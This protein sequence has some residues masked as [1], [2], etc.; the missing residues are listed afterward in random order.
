MPFDL[1][2]FERGLFRYV[3]PLGVIA[4]LFVVGVYAYLGVFSRYW[5][6]D[7]CETVR[8]QN[9]SSPITAILQRYEEG[10]WRAANRYSNLTFVG[11]SEWLGPNNL[12][13]TI[14][15]MVLLWAL[16]L[17]WS[18][19][20]FR[21]FFK[22]D[23]NFSTDI[24]LGLA[25]EFF[26]L[27]QAPNLFQTIYWRS[28]MMTHFAPL[29][30]GSFLFAFWFRQARQ[31]QKTSALNLA[32]ICL[33][34]FIIAG[35][36]EPPVAA[37]V[38]ALGLLGAALLLWGTPAA[39]Q[40]LLPLTLSAFLGALLGLIV[41]IFSPANFNLM[42]KAPPT[43]LKLLSD[44]FLFAYYFI[45]F[46]FKEL[47]LPNL[48]SAALPF[49]VI[50][51][52]KQIQPSA[53]LETKRAQ[54]WLWVAL[55]PILMWV[56]I[57]A[58]FSPSVYGQGYPIERMRFLARAMMT[59]TFMLEGALLAVALQKL[60]VKI[61]ATYVQWSALVLLGLLGIFYPIRA[62]LNVYQ[63][64][65]AEYRERA[66]LWDA[67]NAYILRHIA[68]GEQDLIIPGYSAPYKVKEIDDDP[69]HWV[70]VCVANFYGVHSV[71]AVSIP[72]PYLSEYLNE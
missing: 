2:K 21:Q 7:Y 10:S 35:F 66:K 61:N 40:K 33:A 14:T 71:R 22:T 49:L 48:L 58:S 24:F 45:A 72:E 43:P 18:V 4:L 67:R 64:N 19:S 65:I 62:G 9:A 60:T 5:S 13:I 44:S 69:A 46:S 63:K 68:L 50:F 20:E 6:D 26:I 54:L 51:A 36:S 15:G 17:S 38:S 52:H 29:V 55:A 8:N 32:F 70:N 12:P 11:F 3:V 56:L 23:W 28:S 34:T 47:P 27:L 41:M 16:G 37:L 25:L 31:A 39:K 42:D 30:F 57:A 53:A 1:N 59:A